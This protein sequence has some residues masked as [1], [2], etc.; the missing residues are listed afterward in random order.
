MNFRNSAFLAI[1]L[2]CLVAYVCADDGSKLPEVDE[3][4]K[5]IIPQSTAHPSDF[6]FPNAL[7]SFLTNGGIVAGAVLAIGA[8]AV[9]LAPI[10]GFKFC[11]LLGTCDSGYS[12]GPSYNDYT[13]YQQ[14]T[15]N[16]AYQKRS[17]EYIGPILKALGNAYD[18]YNK[19]GSPLAT[20]VTK[21]A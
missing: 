10:F 20:A 6:T 19:N 8:L 17:L 5:N 13:G 2:C 1:T 18:K 11:T 15:Y 7:T 21:N 3:H 4:D 9:I 12:A 16:P 14:G